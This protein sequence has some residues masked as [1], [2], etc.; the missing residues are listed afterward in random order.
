[1]HL[2]PCTTLM[3]PGFSLSEYDIFLSKASL[4]PP[5]NLTHQ[6]EEEKVIRDMVQWFKA[7][8]V[9]A[10]DLGLVPRIHMVAHNCL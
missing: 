4:E 5:Y 7:V 1:M 2:S 8:T 3:A 9:L 6:K 10:E